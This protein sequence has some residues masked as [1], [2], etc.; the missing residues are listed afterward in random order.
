MPWF[1]PCELEIVVSALP[2]YQGQHE[3]HMDISE[4]F[5]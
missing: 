2:H 3:D 5:S 4:G 1:S